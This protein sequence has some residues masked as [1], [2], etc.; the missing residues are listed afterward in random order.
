MI[1]TTTVLPQ[2]EENENVEIDLP[3]TSKKAIKIVNF[4]DNIQK[5]TI[6][7]NL[8]LNQKNNMRKKIIV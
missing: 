7:I 4:K 8:I 2:L 1:P 3:K 6:S 5:K